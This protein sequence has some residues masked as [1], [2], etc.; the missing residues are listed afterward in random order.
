MYVS[1]G[2]NKLEEEKKKTILC[3]EVRLYFRF[4]FVLSV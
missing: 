1:W 4:L 2:L 3:L